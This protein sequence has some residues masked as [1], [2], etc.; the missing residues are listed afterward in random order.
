[1]ITLKQIK[2]YIEYKGDGDGFVRSATQEEK[3]IMDYKHWSLIES[4][5]QDI[6]IIK[7]GLVSEVYMK[8]I[9]ERLQKDCDS[10]ETMEALNNIATITD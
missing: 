6:R 8:T 5:V 1:M 3:S 2:I 9:N 10:E 4:F 7:K